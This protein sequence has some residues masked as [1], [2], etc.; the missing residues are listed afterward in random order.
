M[1]R[2]SLLYT[3]LDES[4]R[5]SQK[6]HALERYF[7]EAPPEDAAWGLF[8]L[9]GR[10]LR[11]AVRYSVLKRSAI[12]VSGLPAW[13]FDECHAAVGDFSET[14][15]LLLPHAA[16]E[17]EEGDGD[18]GVPRRAA[19]AHVAP[20]PLPLH[21]LVQRYIT[22]L[23]AGT[24]QQAAVLLKQAWARLSATERFVYHKLLSVNFRVGVQKRLVVR[25][26]ATV[27]HVDP[28]V[29]EHRLM[30]GSAP[31]AEAYLR[32]IAPHAE[33]DDVGRPYPFFLATHLE[34]VP[35][36]TVE[37]RHWQLE[38]KWDGI[39][40][41]LV[42]RTSLNGSP[43]VV[44]WSRG[45]EVITGQFPE[46]S[47][48]A[49]ALPCDAVLDGEVLAWSDQAQ[50]GDSKPVLAPDSG[51]GETPLALVG[52]P[53]PFGVLQT[54]LNRTAA[55]AEP[56]LFDRTDLVF[57]AYDLLECA[58]VDLRARPLAERREQL[59]R[60]AAEVPSE[61]PLRLSPVMRVQEWSEAAA[62]RER[63]STIGAEGLMLKP[64]AS[65]YGVG[66]TRGDLQGD[67]AGAGWWKW[68][69]DPLSLDA[70]LI[71]AQPGSGRRA[72]LYTDY[73]FG[74]WHEGTLLPF[75]KAYSG[76]DDAEIAR[77]DAFVRRHTLA[78]MGP[79]RAVKPQLVFEIAF[80]A[81][82]E[83]P[84]HKS[85]VAVRFPRIARWR[86]DKAPEQAD[87][88][89]AARALLG[90]TRGSMAPLAPVRKSGRAVTPRG[91]R[92]PAPD[93]GDAFLPG[94]EGGGS[95]T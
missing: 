90:L 89:E 58:G 30:G 84:R 73:T 60:L 70:V 33:L 66:R 42:R 13:L 76:L 82:R 6:L 17:G 62:L 78:K 14:V 2:F 29:M 41:Q 61:V 5:T 43:A 40:A 63:A 57:M 25:A 71:A 26:L 94:F 4:N 93:P 95:P 91:P 7:S 74:L 27:A 51:R 10:K 44:V 24:D 54:R 85:G 47:R 20:E 9:T 23:G 87:T 69:I 68:K 55:A 21:Q 46:L 28:A 64:L 67:A 15:A 53:L 18:P 65:P 3:E 56:G 80:E 19:S 31:T 39:R 36:D 77:V 83:S 8:F 32:V 11:R 92:S 45:E 49:R 72:S 50:P 22:P 1:K 16:P 75:A 79:V 52:R 38:W 86:H 12:E 59:E 37:P 88:L 35:S 34:G 81:I 48:I